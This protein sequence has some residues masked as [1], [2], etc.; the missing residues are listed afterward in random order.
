LT[1]IVLLVA[2]LAAADV[3]GVWML[4]VDP[5][6]DGART[7]ARCTFTTEAQRLTVDCGSALQATGDVDGRRVTFSSAPFD[8]PDLPL[9]FTGELDQDSRR[10]RGRWRLIEENGKNKDG[11]FEAVKD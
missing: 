11:A 6:P 5:D 10:I 1:S 3:S 9:T 2:A 8:R 7:S 4:V